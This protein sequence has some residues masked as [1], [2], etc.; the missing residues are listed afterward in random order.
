MS[1]RGRFAGSTPLQLLLTAERIA[2][3]T[4]RD[5]DLAMWVLCAW[6]GLRWGELMGLQRQ[7]SRA[8]S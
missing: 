8:P 3:L 7:P 5:I 6:C 2:L 4:G 1:L